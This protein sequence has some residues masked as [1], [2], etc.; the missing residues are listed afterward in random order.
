MM[1]NIGGAIGI[2]VLQTFLT[3]RE[4]FHSNIITQNITPENPAL[5]PRIDQLT[6]YFLSHGV[7]DPTEAHGQAIAAIAKV[8]REQSYVMAFSDTFFLLGSV[9]IIALIASLF[10]KAGD[11]LS[12]GG[13]H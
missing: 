8:V 1:R 9:L 12:A 6:Q 7:S 5:Q 2:A 3:K 11:K 10:L 13:A 4:Q